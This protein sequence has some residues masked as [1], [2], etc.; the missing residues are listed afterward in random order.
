MTRPPFLLRYAASGPATRPEVSQ[1]R[2]PRYT[3]KQHLLSAMRVPASPLQRYF[4][5][6]QVIV[7]LATA[8]TG[9]VGLWFGW[10]RG[11]PLL[12]ANA[13]TPS[14]DNLGAVAGVLA[15]VLPLVVGAGCVA[16]AVWKLL[17]LW[18]R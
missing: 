7:A 9:I 1:V 16:Y 4:T 6:L 14:P 18:S 10:S 17:R 8:A 12:W 3:Q 2:N 13:A 5:W 15:G 11:L